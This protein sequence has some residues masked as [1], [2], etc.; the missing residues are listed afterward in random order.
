NKKW[1]PMKA[2]IINCYGRY[3]W[4]LLLFGIFTIDRIIL[5]FFEF[6]VLIVFPDAMF[7]VIPVEPFGQQLVVG[8]IIAGHTVQQ[9]IF[10]GKFLEDRSRFGIPCG[11]AIDF[12]IDIQRPFRHGSIVVI[13][14][15]F[16]I[17]NALLIIDFGH[18]DAIF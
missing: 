11:L 15:F 6:A 12:A 7:F 5:F 1:Q 13:H 8:I 3:R 9:A 2:A 18:Q 17:Q 10:I 14:K 16:A 4:R